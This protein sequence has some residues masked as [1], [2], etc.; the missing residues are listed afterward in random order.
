MKSFAS[1]PVW[2]ALSF[3][4][5]GCSAVLPL[6]DEY[7]FGDGVDGGGADGGGV[8]GGGVDGGGGDASV[9]PDGDVPMDDAGTDAGC[10]VPTMDEVCADRCGEIV[11]CGQAFTCGTCEGELS[12]GGA[13]TA[14]VCGCAEPPCALFTDSFGDAAIQL[15]RG[16]AV[17][18]EGNVFVAGDFRGTITFGDTTHTNAGSG[19]RYDMF[20]V[21]FDRSGN[22]LWSRSFGGAAD[23]TTDRDQRVRGLAVDGAGNVVLA[24]EGSG[25][26]SFG[27]A[28]LEND[29]LIAKF[30]GD[31][32][33]LWSAAYGTEFT[34][35]PT[36]IAVD[37]GTYDVVMTGAFWGTLRF[38]SLS[39]MTATGTQAYY[40]MFVVR[41]R[42]ADGVPQYSRRFGDEWEQQPN[43]VAVSRSH[44][45]IASTFYGTFDFGA[46]NV[47]TLSSSTYYSLAIA[48]LG[49]S[50]F[51]HS[52]SSSFGTNVW[53][54]ELAADQNG[55]LF[56]SGG[57]SDSLDIIT[58][59]LTTA[60]GAAFLAKLDE[61]GTTTWARQ[62]ENVDITALAVGADNSIYFAGVASGDTDLGGG[63][64]SY[65]GTRDAFI[66]HLAADGT[67][68]FSR[69][70]VS[71]GADQVAAGIGASADGEVWAG[72][73]FQG[74][75]DLG[76][77]ELRTAGATDIA[78][79]RYV[80]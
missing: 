20:L 18:Y 30:N 13:G 66:A 14:N 58:P 77:G 28:N 49:V 80:P 76:T 26:V 55:N 16:L 41:F 71:A 62:Y 29:I 73:D 42:A 37:P 47:T 25:I 68:L 11:V 75:V 12:C 33:H 74:N 15:I 61:G 43:S 9:T 60:A 57:F 7:T 1:S 45:Y 51:T 64:I 39:A 78:I 5:C 53:G 56:V 50:T 19:S 34:S 35:Y 48:R 70:F 21:K 4:A 8:D 3:F 38:G 59:A 46:P 10:E 17:D 65:S 27:G 40:D 22:V 31:G 44:V 69:V 24:G 63:S 2:L 67:H 32:E 52:W 79:G 72:F 54:V 6:G 36:A 23:A